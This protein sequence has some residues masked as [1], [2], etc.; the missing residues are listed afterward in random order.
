ML[1]KDAG[2]EVSVICDGLYCLRR[3]CV[4]EVGVAGGK[5]DRP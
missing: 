5:E 4:C 2:T 1:P 3:Y